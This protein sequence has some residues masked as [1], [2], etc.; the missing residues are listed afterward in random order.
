MTTT[1]FAR[2]YGPWALIA[3]ASEGVGSALAE[4][5]AALGLNVALLARR[6]EVLDQVAAGIAER[7]G[8]QTRTL[9]VDLDDPDAA[10]TIAAAL[11]DREVGFL[12]YCAGA[13]GDCLPFLDQPVASAEALIRRNCLVP[14]QVI[15]ALAGPMRERGRGAIVTFSSGAAFVGGALMAVYGGS[16]A[17]DLVFTEALW[18]ELEPHGVHVLGVVL[19][20]TDTP[21]LRR[22]QSGDADRPVKGA[23]PV[24]AVVKG[25][26]ANLDH[27]PTLMA[28]AQVKVG[29]KLFGLLPRRAGVRMLTKAAAR[30]IGGDR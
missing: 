29:S 17:F 16:K 28:S 26:L 9:A 18:A 2:R 30:T 20:E 4:E 21:A 8:V 13:D 6:A 27:G 1:D 5:L 23:T 25:I 12:A 7:T 15:H 10:A 14:A 11:A 3:G 19:G 22:L 24:A